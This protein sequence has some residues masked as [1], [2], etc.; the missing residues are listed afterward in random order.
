MLVAMEGVGSLLPKITGDTTNGEVHLRQL[1]GGVSIF[2]PIDRDIELIPLVGF[3]ELEALHK[4][5]ARAT[6]RV[7]DASTIRFDKL[8]HQPYNG[9]RCIELAENFDLQRTLLS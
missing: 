8:R 3:D 4:H 2:L 1:V 6:A 9:L 7:I 5:T